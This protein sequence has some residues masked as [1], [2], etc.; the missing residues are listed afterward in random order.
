MF[1]AAPKCWEFVFVLFTNI[2]ISG[3]SLY[4]CLKYSFTHFQKKSFLGHSY[5]SLK[6]TQL[7]F[8]VDCTGSSCNMPVVDVF[9]FSFVFCRWT[10]EFHIPGVHTNREDV[11]S[12]GFKLL[13]KKAK[14]CTIK[15]HSIKEIFLSPR[16]GGV[17][18]WSS[19]FPFL[20]VTGAEN[21]HIHFF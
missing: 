16:L 7:A 1:V 6:M 2:V 17:N 3:I 19:P 10:P 15:S 21:K 12:T 13:I 9:A 18:S 20:F 4:S 14:C 8:N 5:Y 11:H